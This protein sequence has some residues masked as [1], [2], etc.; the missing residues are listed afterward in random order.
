MPSRPK[1]KW[2]GHFRSN[3]VSADEAMRVVRQIKMRNQRKV[4]PDMVVA[5]AADINSPI[6]PIFEWDDETAAY[7]YRKYQARNML[8]SLIVVRDERTYHHSEQP[9]IRIMHNVA[10]EEGPVYMEFDDIMADPELT[11][12]MVENALLRLNNWV[13]IY[14]AYRDMAEAT[15]SI[16]EA[17]ERIK[18]LRG[19]K[20][21]SQGLQH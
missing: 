21:A 17:I 2:R 13:S 15:L 9:E 6:H 20:T 11:D 14:G 3:G 4:T 8:G 18:A 10:T 16:E 19:G 5:E 12:Q 7:E 1:A